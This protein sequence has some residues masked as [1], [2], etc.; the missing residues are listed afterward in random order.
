MKRRLG[1]TFVEV[2]LFLAITALLFVGITVGTQNS[3]NQ[4]RFTDTVESFADFMRNVY[5]DV[6]NPMSNGDGTSGQAIYGKLVVFGE[7]YD[8]SG[9]SNNTGGIFTYDVLGDVKWDYDRTSSIKELLPKLRLTPYYMY[10]T[11]VNSMQVKKNFSYAGIAEDYYPKWSSRIESKDKT[12]EDIKAAVLVIRHPRSGTIYTLVNTESAMKI[13]EGLKTFSGTNLI[14]DKQ[15]RCIYGCSLVNQAN[16]L[17][18]SFRNSLS[19]FTFD[20]VSFCVNPF[21]D[22]NKRQEVRLAE[23]SRNSSGVEV[24][25]L[26]SDDNQCNK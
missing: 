23:N 14:F 18:K 26:D 1:F 25:G 6:S 7:S 8:F 24:I 13:N 12:G 22:S 3:I 19:D 5:S 11:P 17:E 2:S 16:E 4:Q 21:G 20:E 9:E 10:E 15:G